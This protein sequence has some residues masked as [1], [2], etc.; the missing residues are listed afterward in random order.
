MKLIALDFRRTGIKALDENAFGEP[1]QQ[2]TRR[3]KA[4]LTGSEPFGLDEIRNDFFRRHSRASAQTSQRQ[5]GA[6][7]PQ[8]LPPA[9]CLMRK[10]LIQQLGGTW[11]GVIFVYAAPEPRRSEVMIFC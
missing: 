3:V 2:K 1:T 11:A 7:E 6:H 5:R 9:G 8:E 4:G 10:L